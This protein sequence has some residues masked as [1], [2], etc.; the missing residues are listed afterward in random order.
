MPRIHE[1]VEQV[2]G[3][4]PGVDVSLLEK[5]YVYSAKVHQG[6]MRLS[7]E[8]YLTHPLAVA[9][10]LAEMRLDH[11]T[12]AAGLLHDTVEDTLA[13][14]ADIRAQFGPEIGDLV[15]GLT[16]LSKIEFQ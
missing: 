9:E 11:V 6:Q 10:L 3:H 16:K 1:I 7:G 4:F 5:A 2:Q 13:T 14:D 15:A 12:V 8:P